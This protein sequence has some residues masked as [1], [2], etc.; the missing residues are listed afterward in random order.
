MSDTLKA[1]P[2]PWQWVAGY[3]YDEALVYDAKKNTVCFGLLDS[4][5]R[6]IARAVNDHA[7]LRRMVEELLDTLDGGTQAPA[8]R[9]AL[10]RRARGLLEVIAEAD[11]GGEE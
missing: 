10:K 3:E 6:L 8:A 5:A 11:A 7:P 1:S 2:R 4:D 9:E